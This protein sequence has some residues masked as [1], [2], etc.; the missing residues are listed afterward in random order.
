VGQQQLLL[1]ILGI[2][3]VAVAI[4][5]SIQ[6]FRTNAIDRKREILVDESQNIAAIALSYYKRPRMM[7]GGGKSFTGWQIP[8]QLVSTESGSYVSLVFSDSVVITGTGTEVVTGN[9]SIKVKT[10]VTGNKIS[11]TILY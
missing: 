7:G 3:I 10:T 8:T 9:D 5:L 6:L 2:I 4:A 1:V 11:S